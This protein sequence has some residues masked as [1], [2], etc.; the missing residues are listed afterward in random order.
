MGAGINQKSINKSIEKSKAEK[1]DQNRPKEPR[2]EPEGSRELPGGAMPVNPGFYQ[3]QPGPNRAQPG[4]RE[5]S[6]AVS[7]HLRA[8]ITT[9]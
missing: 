2:R 4:F 7:L 8:V 6:L 9:S 3:A 5:S 1:S